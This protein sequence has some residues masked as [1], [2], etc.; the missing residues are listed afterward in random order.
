MSQFVQTQWTPPYIYNGLYDEEMR[1][2]RLPAIR[3]RAA[4]ITSIRRQRLEREKLELETYRVAICFIAVYQKRIAEMKELSWLRKHIARMMIA[5][6]RQRTEELA[7]RKELCDVIA[8]YSGMRF[9]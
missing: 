7:Q 3:A 1:I 4:R 5:V 8:E 9:E 6:C 2:A